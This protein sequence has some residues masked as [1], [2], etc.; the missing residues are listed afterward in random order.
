MAGKKIQVDE[1]ILNQQYHKIKEETERLTADMKELMELING[2][3]SA[4]EGAAKK[5]FQNQAAEAS[6]EFSRMSQFLEEYLSWLEKS[7]KTYGDCEKEI[8]DIIRAIRI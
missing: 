5:E 8:R 2:L 1:V 4:W 7:I 6:L 3:D